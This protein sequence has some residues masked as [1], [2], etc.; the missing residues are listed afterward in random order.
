MRTHLD[1]RLRRYRRKLREDL[2]RLYA[3]R[4]EG[5]RWARPLRASLVRAVIKDLRQ[6]REMHPNIG[7]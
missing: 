3:R 6:H 5:P 1:E 2:E 7:G 4:N